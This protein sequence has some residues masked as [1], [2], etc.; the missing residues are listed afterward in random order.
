M[1]RIKLTAM[2]LRCCGQ[3]KHSEPDGSWKASFQ[4]TPWPFWENVLHEI[5]QSLLETQTRVAAISKHLK[6]AHN[7]NTLLLSA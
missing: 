6:M 3:I 1:V 2:L 4:D 7:F 5:N